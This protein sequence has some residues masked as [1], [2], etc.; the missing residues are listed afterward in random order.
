[1]V[2]PLARSG[3][4]GASALAGTV[5]GMVT[6]QNTAAPPS[7]RISKAI[8]R[9]RMREKL[10]D[11]DSDSA[12][13]ARRYRL[14]LERPARAS[15][16]LRP[17]IGLVAVATSLTHL[18]ERDLELIKRLRLVLVV[19]HDLA[20]RGDLGLEVAFGLPNLRQRPGLLARLRRLREQARQLLRGLAPLCE[21][22]IDLGGVEGLLALHHLADRAGI[23]SVALHQRLAL[24]DRVG[25]GDDDGRADR[26]DCHG[27]DGT[28]HLMAPSGAW[29]LRRMARFGGH[30]DKH[31]RQ[32][33]YSRP[34]AAGE[35]PIT[36]T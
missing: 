36:M 4:W 22:G 19:G 1:M 24:C 32:L 12:A 11:R 20:E 14:R 27:K 34:V 9:R 10:Q 16:L 26:N 5:A 35:R 25:L 30:G 3:V 29:F 7:T 28:D 2:L 23:L 31:C 33:L 15:A 8:S 6:N 21:R 13:R 18:P 17:A